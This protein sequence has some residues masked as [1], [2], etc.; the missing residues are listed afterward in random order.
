MFNHSA[1]AAL[2]RFYERVWDFEVLPTSTALVLNISED[3]RALSG[4][5]KSR[6]P[7]PRSPD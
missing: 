3:V 4:L 1:A 5:A 6:S 7:L 2:T